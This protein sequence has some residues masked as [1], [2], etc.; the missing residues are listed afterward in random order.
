V[1]AE[2]A[3]A[4]GFSGVLVPGLSIAGAEF[5]AV[6]QLDEYELARRERSGGVVSVTDRSQ[7]RVL[8]ELP[9]DEA[10]A[11]ETLD[12]VLAAVIDA[13]PE[14]TVEADSFEVIR[15]FR[16]ALN[17]EGVIKVSH[18]RVLADLAEIG[19]LAPDAARGLVTVHTAITEHLA[20]QAE[21]MGVGLAA[22]AGCGVE[23]VV[24]PSRR[25]VVPP[26]PRRWRVAEL[27]FERWLNLRKGAPTP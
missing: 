24:A 23:A 7:L 26:N 17:I 10:V 1:I 22:I 21:S 6:A 27:V 14:G 4:F 3:E 20:R 13:L 5:T 2:A 11:W 12:P 25:Y 18:G 9:L 16:P 8:A 15:R 19:W